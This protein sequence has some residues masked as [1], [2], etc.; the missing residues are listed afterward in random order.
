MGEKN[1]KN[2]WLTLFLNL[3]FQG[4]STR[5]FNSQSNHSNHYIET[6][7]IEIL[8]ALNSYFDFFVS[9]CLTYSAF[10]RYFSVF[11]LSLLQELSIKCKN[12]T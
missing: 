3:I 7:K 10:Y 8:S 2:V 9:I 11:I 6:L 4:I 5:Q 1:L 12:A